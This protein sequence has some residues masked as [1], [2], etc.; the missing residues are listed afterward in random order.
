MLSSVNTHNSKELWSAIGNACGSNSRRCISDFGPPFDDMDAM[1][2][3]FASIA[4]D[5]DY[6]RQHILSHVKSVMTD[7]N[8]T[9]LKLLNNI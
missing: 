4:S 8:P 9:S 2:K 5:P 6:D 3:F 1:N 7:S